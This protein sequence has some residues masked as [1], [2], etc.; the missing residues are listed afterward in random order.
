MILTPLNIQVAIIKAYYAL[1]KKS[2]KYYTGL[3]LGKNNTCLFK[4]IRLLR[5]YVEIL[6]NF[7]IV[8]STDS[9]HCCIQGNYI[10]SDDIAPISPIQFLCDGTM[11]LFPDTFTYQ[12]DSD[13]SNLI[14]NFD[15]DLTVFTGIT[16]T[17]D[18]SFS[19]YNNETLYTFTTDNPCT[20]TTI[21]QTCLNNNQVTKIIEHV[22]KL[23]R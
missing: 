9:C 20:S 14:W 8:G 15:G 5:A 22:N 21:E 11:Y 12:Y 18:C 23:V 13:N 10:Y 17:S 3:A 1:A 19:G 7:Q 16:F 2:V 6:K 4:E